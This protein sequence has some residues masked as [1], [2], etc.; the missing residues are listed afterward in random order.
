MDAHALAA[1]K[2]LPGKSVAMTD[3]E[4]DGFKL[5]KQQIEYD[6]QCLRVARTRR[7]T[8]EG[9][10]HHQLLTHRKH[11]HEVSSTAADAFFQTNVKVLCS[12][13][14]AEVVQ[15]FQQFEKQF[16]SSYALDQ[17]NTVPWNVSSLSIFF[18]CRISNLVCPGEGK[19]AMNVGRQLLG[20]YI[21]RFS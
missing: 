2:K 18:I 1:G 8:H 5:L 12:T 14:A 19:Q 13:K 10:V 21:V 4:S 11:A 16:C 7:A 9:A 17:D 6:L 3:L 20:G 15:A